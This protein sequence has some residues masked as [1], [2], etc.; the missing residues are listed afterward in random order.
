MQKMRYARRVSPP[1]HPISLRL[2]APTLEH[3]DHEAQRLGVSRTRWVEQLIAREAAAVDLHGPARESLRDLAGRLIARA[4]GAA[5]SATVGVRY[6][7]AATTTLLLNGAPVDDEAALAVR[8]VPILGGRDTLPLVALAVQTIRAGSPGVAG[9]SALVGLVP[10]VLG[11]RAERP[12]AGL[13]HAY[14]T[15]RDTV[16]PR[17]LPR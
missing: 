10:E 15:D 4:G 1:K 7:G 16:L 13:E 5:S 9:F 2:D 14:F 11:A 17:P 8:S 6:D 12:I 3:V